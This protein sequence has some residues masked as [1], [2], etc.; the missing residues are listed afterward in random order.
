MKDDSK[1]AFNAEGTRDFL[2]WS[3]EKEIAIH[4][5]A[6]TVAEIS[7]GRKPDHVTIIPSQTYSGYMMHGGVR[8]RPGI[9][10]KRT[11]ISHI[12]VSM[13]GPIAQNRVS[14]KFDSDI[15]AFENSKTDTDSVKDTLN[16][17]VENRYVSKDELMRK[18]YRKADRFLNK[19][20]NMDLI[21]ALAHVLRDHQTL[22]KDEIIRW[23]HFFKS[24][25]D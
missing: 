5:A 23:V 7:E 21:Y 6:H 15:E 4:E 1:K 22:N 18:A 14:G 16:N 8:L 12:F 3:S 20:E 17:I 25:M 11:I 19:Q 2:I 9:K 24:K 13:V 10:T